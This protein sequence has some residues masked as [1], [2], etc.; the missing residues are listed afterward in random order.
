V[1]ARAETPTIDKPDAII[2]GAGAGGGTAA[3]VLT[4][5]GWSVVVFE[6]GPLWTAEDFLPYDELHFHEHKALIPHIDVDPNVYMGGPN[7]D[8]PTPSERWWI[9]NMVGGATMIW[10]ANMPRYTREDFEVTN[11]LPD[12]LDGAEAMVDWP[13]TYDEFQPWFELAEWEW[14]MSGKA[15]Q[16]PAQEPMRTGYDYPMP[17]IRAHASSQFLIDS[18]M[19]AGMKPYFGPHAINSQTYDGR[20]A[21]SYCGF[22]QFFGCAVNSRASSANTVLPRAIATGRCDL[23]L[24]H[25]VTR[26]GFENGKATGVHYL[27]PDGNEQFL[28]APLVFVS[29]QTIESARL[30]LYSEVPDPNKMIGHYLTYH[31]KGDAELTFPLQ[32]AWDLGTEY[33]PRTAIGS[34]QL[35]DLY[36]IDDAKRPELRKGGKF[37]IYD[38]YTW[39]T[40]IRLLKGAFFGPDKPSIWGDDLRAYMEELRHQGGVYFSF[41][42]DAISL[43]DN[44]VELDPD[45]KDPWGIPVARTYYRHHPYDRAVSEYCL[46][47]VCEIMSE[48]GGEVR[49]LLPQTEANPGYGHVHGTLRAG[50]DPAASVLDENCQSHTVKNLYVLDNAFMPTAG[51]SNPTLTLLAN[52]YRVC[53]NVPSP[54]D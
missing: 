30:F 34:L 50:T 46:D 2:V 29:I 6:K 32:P 37:S 36:V 8:T 41:T 49:R 12:G 5:R 19:K 10:D 48:A 3:R 22:N 43:Y 14:G 40:P 17:P 21:C 16:A 9:V 4:Q 15:G 11:Y 42:G 20:P 45:R 47:R 33:Q 1:S 18:F 35:R 44:R 54:R 39:A 52:A 31:A 7:F 25:C 26:L 28:A 51:A 53:S 24:E 27:D 38:P 23:R 13:W